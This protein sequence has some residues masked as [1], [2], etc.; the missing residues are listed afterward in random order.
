MSN[1][2]VWAI[3]YNQTI[4][5]GGGTFHILD[6]HSITTGY[7]VGAI[8][9][10]FAIVPVKDTLAFGRAIRA[11]RQQYMLGSEHVKVDAIGTWV[12]AGMIYID[13]VKVVAT[14]AEAI[15]IAKANNQLAYFNLNENKEVRL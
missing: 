1:S 3:Y 10:T 9:D 14:E 13:P 11:I 12:D 2:Q 7:A 4:A 5:N 8:A 15:K 6:T